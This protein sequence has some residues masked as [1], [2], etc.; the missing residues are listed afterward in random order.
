MNIGFDG[1]R[2]AN[3]LT[4]LGNYSRS[5]ITQLA[6]FFP[7]NQYFVYT[8]KIKEAPQI[9]HFFNLNNVLGVLPS[10]SKF[11]WRTLTIKN[12][13]LA[14]QIDV[15]HGLSHEIPF[16]IQK[17][18]IAS[19]VTIHDLIFLK[20]P[21]YFGRID[22]FI[23]TLKCKYACTNADKIVAISEQTKKDII[24]FFNIDKEKIE[25]VYQGCDESFKIQAEDVLKR[26][27]K[28]KFALPDQYILNVGTI[29]T[30]KNLLTLI[31]ALPD[32]SAGYTLVVVGKETPYKK[33]I[34]DEIEKLSLR[35]RVIFLEDVPFTEL[36][37]IYQMASVFVYPSFYEGFGI[38]IIEALYS[39]VPVIAAT[40]SC[41]E[42]AGGAGSLYINPEDYAELSTTINRVLGDSSLQIQ[43]K[44]TGLAYAQRFNDNR[45]ATDIM[46]VYQ[47]AHKHKL[48]TYIR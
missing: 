9:K 6:Q 46:K 14:D 2:A 7:Q 42:E 1:K 27:V 26:Q 10:S 20:F 12:Q 35:H 47:D 13:L 23:Y 18:A 25:V 29:E 38:P 44:L 34:L 36:P 43:M 41:L 48:N 19:I 5:L 28:E 24:S 40:G 3:N 30:R 31:K 32:V 37:A 15:Y 33:F 11:L 17:T 4:G 8:P 39:E 22:R 21:H 45:I 16:G